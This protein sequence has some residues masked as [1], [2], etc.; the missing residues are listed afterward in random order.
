[1]HSLLAFLLQIG[2]IAGPILA[3]LGFRTL[4]GSVAAR[5]LAGLLLAVAT[6]W[7]AAWCAIHWGWQPRGK[8]GRVIESSPTALF[9][10]FGIGLLIFFVFLS[11]GKKS[12][13]P[14]NAAGWRVSHTGRDQMLYEE[15]ANGAWRSLVIDGEMLLG[16]AHHVIYFRSADEWTRYPDWAQG[17]RDEIIARIK[18]QFRPPDYEY[19]ED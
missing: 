2:L 14:P 10:I 19:H 6:G 5:L 13:P 15:R 9:W 7:L 11:F 3:F 8:A 16:P 12:G 17:R 1:M 18:S 4:T